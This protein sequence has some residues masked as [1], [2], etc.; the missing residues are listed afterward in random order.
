MAYTDDQLGYLAVVEGGSEAAEIMAYP[1][2]VITDYNWAAAHFTLREQY[3]AQ[4]TRTLGLNSRESKPY[5]RDM[6]VRFYIL[7]SEDASSGKGKN[8]PLKGMWCAG[9]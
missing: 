7:S 8:I 9:T 3:I 2:G 5:M 4:T 1:A 6:T